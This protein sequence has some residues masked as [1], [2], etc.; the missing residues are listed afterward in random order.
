[1]DNALKIYY[2]IEQTL[3]NKPNDQTT[4]KEKC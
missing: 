4:L 1:M 3:K 2:E